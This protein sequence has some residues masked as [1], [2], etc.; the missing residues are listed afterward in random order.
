MVDLQ[1]NVR[2][3]RISAQ[4]TQGVIHVVA[5][6]KR[7]S[8]S[9]PHQLLVIMTFSALVLTLISILFLRN[10]VRPI[11]RL[12]DAAEA[13]GKG[14]VATYRPAGADEVRRAGLAF[15]SMRQRIERHLEQ[16]TLMLSGV[17]HD[18]RTPLTRMRL[19][20]ATA[21]DADDLA[22]L[23]KDIEDMEAM[24]DS[25]IE[26]ARDT[27]IEAAQPVDPVK[28]VAAVVKDT[29]QARDRL[30]FN[31][32]TQR[33]GPM[34][35]RVQALR[36][37]VQNLIDNALRYAD[38]AEVTVEMSASALVIAVEDNGPGIPP[39]DAERATRAFTRLDVAR[40]Q[41][42]GAGSGLGLAIVLDVARAHGGQLM[43]HKS[44]RLGGL[45][46][47]LSLPR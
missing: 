35:L 41:D 25:F 31:D 46:A 38:L 10:Q 40:N 9:N 8:A 23:T 39:E 18:L 24:I 32:N 14:R 37:A 42:A 2:E 44:A 29:P 7:M 20:I 36:R 30:K 22:A 27:S 47:S 11:A 28:L 15:M 19:G 43:L 16:R 3:A 33:H 21:T 17:S 1:S 6:R 34:P 12:A 45:K 13:F 4:T 26:F 5:P